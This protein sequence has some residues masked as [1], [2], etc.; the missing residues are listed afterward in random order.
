MKA[1]VF[2]MLIVDMKDRANDENGGNNRNGLRIACDPHAAT[3]H[4][5]P[6]RAPCNVCSSQVSH[7]SCLIKNFN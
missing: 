5:T 1:S 3:I 2:H 7:S 6:A 4:P